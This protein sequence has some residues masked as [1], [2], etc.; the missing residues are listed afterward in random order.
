M[1]TSELRDHELLEM[2]R[3]SPM[4]QRAVDERR[5]AN[6]QAQKAA[7]EDLARHDAE[8]ETRRRE[9]AAVVEKAKNRLDDVKPEY[10]AALAAF[11]DASRDAN[12]WQMSRAAGRDQ[13]AARIRRHADPMLERFRD[14]LDDLLQATRNVPTNCHERDKSR[15]VGG[16]STIVYSRLPSLTRRMDYLLNALAEVNAMRER[17]VEDVAGEID[18]IRSGIPDIEEEPYCEKVREW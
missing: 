6:R 3:A 13:L 9:L 14:E 18:R 5:E 10:D 7:A 1:Q 2:L 17:Y 16:T 12:L 4:A 15:L 8:T 11:N